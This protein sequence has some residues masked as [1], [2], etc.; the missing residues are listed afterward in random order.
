[1]TRARLLSLATVIAVLLAGA[2]AVAA[3]RSPA[4]GQAVATGPARG[5]ETITSAPPPDGLVVPET[6]TTASTPTTMT[7][8]TAPPASA[9][10]AAPRTTSTTKRVAPT[11]VAPQPTTTT[12]P[13]PAFTVSPTS[14]R[15]GE[16]FTSSGGGCAGPSYGVAVYVYA[17]DGSFKDGN[18][19]AS[20]ADGTWWIP[21]T[22]AASPPWQPGTYRVHAVCR[23]P[24]AVVFAYADQHLTVTA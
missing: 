17:P 7:P 5:D 19:G 15:P 12:V 14:A 1:V 22:V 8:T 4:G 23:Q 3:T 9:V 2:I 13:A 21:M 20:L 16:D 18:S 10:I 6:A 11:T 24:G